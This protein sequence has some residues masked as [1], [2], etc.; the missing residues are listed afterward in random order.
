MEQNVYSDFIMFKA[1]W[2]SDRN[3]IPE[4]WYQQHE[5][6]KP[7]LHYIYGYSTNS[8]LAS[9]NVSAFQD[10]MDSF[11][12]NH[13]SG[14]M[15]TSHSLNDKTTPEE[16]PHLNSEDC[17]VI[18][19]SGEA[20]QDKKGNIIPYLENVQE[21]YQQAFEKYIIT[22]EG[23]FF[24]IIDVH[25]I[26]PVE[27]D[28]QP[29]QFSHAQKLIVLQS[30]SNNGYHNYFFNLLL[31]TIKQTG[32][33]IR[34]SDL[35][36]RLHLRYYH[37][38]RKFFPEMYGH[39]KEIIKTWLF[40]GLVP[41]KKTEQVYY[42]DN[43]VAWVIGA[44]LQDGVIPSLK[45]MN[46][47]IKLEDDRV[48]RLNEVRDTYSIIDGFYEEDKE[49]IFNAEFLQ[50]AL[51]KIKIG[52]GEDLKDEMKDI[53]VRTTKNF[54]LYFI[55]LVENPKD[56]A[57]LIRNRE[58][59]YFLTRHTHETEEQ[60]Y[61]MFFHQPDVFE[62]IK[63]IEYI[64]QWNAVIDLDNPQNKIPSDDY[65]IVFESIEGQ[66]ITKDNTNE[67]S[68]QI[69]IDPKNIEL[70]YRNEIAPTFR[71]HLEMKNTD[72]N[73]QY[74]VNFLYMSGSY[75]IQN[76]NASNNGL[77]RSTE[78][79]A[80]NISGNGIVWTFIQDEYINNKINELQD[81]LLVFISKEPITLNPL[82]QEYLKFRTE[83]SRSL[84]FDERTSKQTFSLPR[85][86]WTVKKIP[87]RIL[88]DHR[89]FKETVLQTIKD[90][91]ILVPNDLQKK[92]WGGQPMNKGF[93]LSAEVKEKTLSLIG[94]YEVT[95]RVAHTT[96]KI[97][98]DSRVAILLHNSFNDSLRYLRFKDGKATVTVTAY[99]DFTTA[100]ILYDGTELELDL[101]EI[102][103]LP[104]KF[105]A[106]QPTNPFKRTVKKLLQ[107]EIR[108][109]D[110]LQKGRWGESPSS[111]DWQ[112]SA[113]VKTEN[114]SHRIILTVQNT[115]QK[116]EKEVAFLLHDS[117]G[118]EQTMFAKTLEGTARCS[119]KS[120][121]AF[122]VGIYIED[123]TKLELNLNKQEGF[124]KSFYYKF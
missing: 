24:I 104:R 77:L 32:G 23:H 97:P 50:M 93:I 78:K 79:V 51:P 75:G 49:N 88:Y 30:Y 120:Y 117:F 29:I 1:S 13:L 38:N 48:Y 58:N 27:Y 118:E 112:L 65:E 59:R 90:R 21:G 107:G 71:C 56:A 66:Q 16:L 87:I 20:R 44:G 41:Y 81:F 122:T 62:F 105:Y 106:Y 74:Y 17:C 119:F 25:M 52:F 22:S 36:T 121:E 96:K 9:R 55:D 63:E 111:N 33:N 92:R 53:F 103:G 100:A 84:S 61:S 19:F 6:I 113:E 76:F 12:K 60:G 114:D 123:G 64:A 40:S 7:K 14:F 10:M 109:P 80:V 43:I 34:Y 57:F 31:E 3:D 11:L 5:D 47:L 99:E 94:L 54:G 95:L 101:S 116:S 67:V 45:F 115:Q 89:T 26:Q 98:D 8:N 110:D 108:F 46:T 86:D 83:T 28:I 102:P 35:I 15:V 68:G 37:D 2:N 69:H 124:P 82:E 18:F 70:K 72:S 42:N 4:N 91:T 85:T 73:K 39:Q